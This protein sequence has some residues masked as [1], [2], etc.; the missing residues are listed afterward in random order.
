[1]KFIYILFF[2]STVSIAQKETSAAMEVAARIDIIEKH[3]MGK[4][5]MNIKLPNSL[6]C[7][8]K[9]APQKIDGTY[10]G[11]VY[12]PTLEDVKQ[13]RE[14][15]EKNKENVSFQLKTTESLESREILFEYEK[16]KFRSSYCK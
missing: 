6:V 16:G 15:L 9:I 2:I 1:M 11:I 13:W 12:Y 8:T 7:L 4:S 5:N 3:I 10:V 14:W